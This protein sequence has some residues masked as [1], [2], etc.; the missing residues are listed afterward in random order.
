M[1]PKAVMRQTNH[2]LCV[3]RQGNDGNV[4]TIQNNYNRRQHMPLF[5]VFYKVFY[6]L[7]KG[8]IL[9]RTLAT[10]FRTLK[11]LKRM[12]AN[13]LQGHVLTRQPFLEKVNLTWR[14]FGKTSSKA[15]IN[16]GQN[17]YTVSVLS[18][19]DEF[20]SISH[21]YHSVISEIKVLDFFCY[22]QNKL[23]HNTLIKGRP[24]F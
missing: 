22:W 10:V 7:S 9:F 11:A 5:F 3:H 24:S 21:F 20:L 19:F 23:E 16:V 6:R 12:A 1:T 15:A 8:L 13:R 2:D 17:H 14:L 4:K 18:I